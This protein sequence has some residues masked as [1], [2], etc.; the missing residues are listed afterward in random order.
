MTLSHL[1]RARYAYIPRIPDVLR[2]PVESVTA[3]KGETTDSVAGAAEM[4]PLFPRTYGR[5]V[6]HFTRGE[7]KIEKKPI[8]V[9]AILSGGQAPGGHNVIAGLYDGIKGAHKESQLF[10]FLGG[11]EG[12]ISGK[13]IEITEE[14]INQYRNTGG[15]DLIGSGRTKIESPE[16]IAAAAATVKAMA[17]N[18]V[19]IIGGDDSNTNAAVLSEY[20]LQEGIATQI[21]GVPKTIDG[22]LKYDMV[23]TSFGFDTATK[24]YSDLIGNIARD[25]NSAKKYWHFIKLMGRYASH[26]TLECALRT[27]PNIC[28]IAEEVAEKQMTLKQITEIIC[29]AVIKRAE[30]KENFGVVL[31]PEGI[32]EFIP[33]IEKLI[34]ELNAAMAQQPE[35]FNA[36]ET[37]KQ[38]KAWIEKTISSESA[39]L[40][41]SMPDDISAQFLMDRDPHGNLQVSRIETEHL[42]IGLVHKRLAELKK[43]G[44]YKGKFNTQAHFFGYEGRAEFPSNFDADYC[45]A[46]GRTIFLLIANGLT[47]YMAS[48]YN[49]TAPPAEWKPCGIP[50]TKLMDMEI[51]SG[52][53]KPVIKKTVVDLN[54]NPFKAFAERREQWAVET[55]Y[56]YPG[57]IQ[58]FGP[59]ELCDAPSETLLLEKGNKGIIP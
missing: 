20:F 58:Y 51:R 55:S 9:A 44:V 16:Q 11:P 52:K 43:A 39:A 30:K 28:L 7:S 34:K 24:I 59:A 8:R 4:Q 35:A 53:K 33:E 5:P 47:G 25:A 40:F 29:D 50:L 10:G 56:I 17:L 49:L 19:V 6:I 37:F 48:V 45:Y 2:V 26:I 14:V 12:L 38:Q 42:L 41:D 46:L 32:I 21:I 31:I 57:P 1:H 3:Q 27:Q 36:L 54:G 18:A 13:H 15:F 23:E 22:D